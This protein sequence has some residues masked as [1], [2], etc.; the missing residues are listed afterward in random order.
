M[1]QNETTANAQLNAEKLER[2]QAD[3]A[4]GVQQGILSPTQYPQP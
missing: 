1:A 4:W 2:A 3:P